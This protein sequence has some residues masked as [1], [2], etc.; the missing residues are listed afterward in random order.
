VA[1][2][3]VIAKEEF[4]VPEAPKTKTGGEEGPVSYEV[5]APV[6]MR[7][8]TPGMVEVKLKFK[9][10]WYG[11][12]N[13]EGNIAGGWIPTKVEYDFPDGFDK[14]NAPIIPDPH[15]KGGAMVYSGDSV[16]FRQQ[17]MK[18]WRTKTGGA[19]AP[20]EYSIGVTIQYQTCNEEKCLPPVTKKLE[21]KVKY[22]N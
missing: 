2:K 3:G 5:K 15:F 11:Y 7:P 21:V 10:G 13:T 9:E 14:M 22:A 4:K 12:A 18:S 6:A 19:L 1:R 8:G 20:G 17:F 16:L